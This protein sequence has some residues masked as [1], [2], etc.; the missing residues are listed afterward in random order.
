M[1]KRQF[2]PRLLFSLTLL[3]LVRALAM[4]SVRQ[5]HLLSAAPALLQSLDGDCRGV[6]RKNV[7]KVLDGMASV[8]W[9]RNPG[10]VSTIATRKPDLPLAACDITRNC[11]RTAG[12]QRYDL[13]LLLLR[14]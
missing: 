6:Q 4:R 8:H 12:H 1:I 7:N 3:C 14:P 13:L 9:P 2:G 5:S 10:P 11:E